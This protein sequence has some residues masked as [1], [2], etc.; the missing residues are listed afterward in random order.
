MLPG[1]NGP[2]RLIHRRLRRT[3]RERT[4]GPLMDRTVA[5]CQM[6]SVEVIVG[7]TRFFIIVRDTLGR[8]SP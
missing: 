2:I 4:A 8:P 3:R 5:R 1:T 7:Q 6:R